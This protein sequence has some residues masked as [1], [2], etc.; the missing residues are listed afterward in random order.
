MAKKSEALA[1]VE[2][3]Q[4]VEVHAEVA[5]DNAKARSVV[6][7]AYKHKYAERAVASGLA[8]KAAQRSCWDWLAQ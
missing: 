2:E 1:K 7:S 5:E 3:A 8:R 6:H 4:V